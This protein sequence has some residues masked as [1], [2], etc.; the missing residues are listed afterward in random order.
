ML[1]NRQAQE[2]SDQI[3]ALDVMIIE[4][5]DYRDMVSEWLAGK[6]GLQQSS[7]GFD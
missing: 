1:M 5:D 6:A 2:L 4:R 7:I 3:R